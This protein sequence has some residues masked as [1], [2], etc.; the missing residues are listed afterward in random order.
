[1]K[2][3]NP[4]RKNWGNSIALKVDVSDKNSVIEAFKQLD[5]L[6]ENIDICINNAGI[7]ELTPIF[8]NNQESVFESIMQTNIVGAWYIIKE[9]AKHMQ[10]RN[11]AGSIINIS[12]VNGANRLREGI[13]A[14]AASKAAVTQMTKALVGELS[15]YNIRINT[16]SPGLVYTP[17]TD[18]KLNTPQLRN[19]ME[20]IIPL[21]FIANPVD[22]NGAVIYLASNKLSRYVTGSCITVDGGV[23]W[24]G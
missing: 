5:N 19:E 24:G 12:S 3:Y 16:I 21:G 1:M 15:P 9:V 4:Y 11:I 10:Q 18:Y 17:L 7:A 2:S 23:S 6:G 20:N 13:T 22:L 8:D 14:Y